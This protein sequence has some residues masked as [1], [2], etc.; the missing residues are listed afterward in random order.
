MW[1][2]AVLTFQNIHAICTGVDPEFLKEGGLN[3]VQANVIGT[4]MF[5]KRISV[6]NAWPRFSRAT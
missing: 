2:V 1:L 3:P 6:N 4:L 5:G